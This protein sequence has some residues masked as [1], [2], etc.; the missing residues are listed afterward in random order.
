M[1]GRMCSIRS[2]SGRSSRS[3]N[4]RAYV[5]RDSMY[6]HCPSAKRVSNARDD[7]PDPE[8][9]V[10]TVSRSWGMSTETFFRLFCRAPS[11]RSHTG[12]DI[13]TVLLRWK[14][15]STG[16][17]PSIAWARASLDRAA[18]RNDAGDQAGRRRQL[19]RVRE[20]P[21]GAAPPG[22]RAEGAAPRGGGSLPFVR[23]REAPAPAGAVR[24]LRHPVH[25][26]RREGGDQ[27]GA[28]PLHGD[29]HVR[30]PASPRRPD[31][32]ADRP[33]LLTGA[34]DGAARVYCMI[35]NQ[36]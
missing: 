25:R 14:V 6:R 5:E 29:R 21:R 10:T 4:M 3:R 2:T 13:R 1:A 11:M 31:R 32:A 22:D 24:A 28:R 33:G 35:M 16:R 27:A 9:P 36:M 12:C 7:L 19:L 23:L 20:G 18:R 15:Y 17:T 34:R 30:A 26:D 8:T